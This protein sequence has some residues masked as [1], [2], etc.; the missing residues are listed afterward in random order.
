MVDPPGL[1]PVWAQLMREV[2]GPKIFPLPPSRSKSGGTKQVAS[3]T[4]R[5]H[6]LA[7]RKKNAPTGQDE[8]DT[9]AKTGPT[10]VEAG[11]QLMAWASKARDCMEHFQI[12]ASYA[13]LSHRLLK[14]YTKLSETAKSVGTTDWTYGYILVVRIHFASLQG[15]VCRRHSAQSAASGPRCRGQSMTCYDML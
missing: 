6:K 14:F 10:K 11:K 7:T 8:H 5:D 2:R 12:T 15:K 9:P 13:G 4:R 1:A 3:P